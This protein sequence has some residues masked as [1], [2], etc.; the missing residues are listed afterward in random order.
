VYVGGEKLEFEGEGRREKR[1]RGREGEQGGSMEGG[2]ESGE[3]GEGV[4]RSSVP[5][6]TNFI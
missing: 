2:E 6:N 4:G 3:S 5:K 1:E